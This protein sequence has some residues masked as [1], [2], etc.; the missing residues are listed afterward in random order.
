MIVDSGKDLLGRAYSYV[1][2]AIVKESSSWHW[3]QDPII[4][5]LERLVFLLTTVSQWGNQEA[6]SL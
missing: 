5:C 6:I 1:A 4:R 2:L 3:I